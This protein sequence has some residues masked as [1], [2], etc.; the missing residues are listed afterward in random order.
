MKSSIEETAYNIEETIDN[1]FDRHGICVKTILVERKDQ[2]GTLHFCQ[3]TFKPCGFDP[4]DDGR[5]L[6]HKYEIDLALGD[7]RFEDTKL[8]FPTDQTFKIV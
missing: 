3:G 2:D 8:I 1:W 4:V 6:A 7:E 5:I